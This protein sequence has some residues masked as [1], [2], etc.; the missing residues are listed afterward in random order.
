M[1][2]VER[3]RARVRDDL[4]PA[5]ARRPGP[6]DDV[7]DE[8]GAEPVAHPIGGDE[9]SVELNRV[10]SVDHRGEPDRDVVLVRHHSHAAG[11]NLLD[12]DVDDLRMGPAR[13]G[14]AP[15]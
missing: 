6:R 15:R 14:T 2:P 11:A 5:R 8:R 13:P 1:T 3:N 12:R 9:Q 4:D 10:T 7:R